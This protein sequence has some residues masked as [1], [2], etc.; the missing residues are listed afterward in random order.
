MPDPDRRQPPVEP[1]ALLAEAG[2]LRSMARRLVS[3]RE[4]ALELEQE[5]WRVA[6]EHPPR[7]GSSL[8]GWLRV[9]ATN[10]LRRHRRD[11]LARGYHEARASS[12]EEDP[13]TST[14]ERLEL[15][16][17]IVEAVRALSEPY[18]TAVTLRHLDGLD[19]AEV[20]RRTG[21]G[22]AA[23]RK[24]VSRGLQEL[25]G[26][27]DRSY[28]GRAGW[29]VFA[30]ALARDL[31]MPS[32]TAVTAATAGVGAGSLIAG[33]LSMSAG[34]KLGAAALATVLMGVSLWW[35][36]RDDGAAAGPSRGAVEPLGIALVAADAPVDEALEPAQVLAAGRVEVD[37]PEPVALAE[38]AAL[39]GI[40]DGRVVDGD[41]APISGAGVELLRIRGL[42][43]ET[44][45][46]EFARAEERLERA[47][48]DADGRFSFAVEP[49]RRYALR[50]G[51]EGMGDAHAARAR[52][53][54]DVTLR[55]MPAGSV[56]GFVSR[57]DDFPAI[58]AVVRLTSKNYGA[59][60]WRAATDGSGAFRFDGLEPGTYQVRA[61]S[62]EGATPNPATVI[63][64]S[65]R[66][67]RHDFELGEG[68]LVRGRVTDADTGAPLAGA[69][70]TES[71]VFH[72]V[73]RTDDNGEFTYAN[74]P[75]DGF[76]DLSIRAAGYG[77]CKVQIRGYFEE[78]PPK[79]YWEIALFPGAVVT[80]RVVDEA[81]TP[82]PD[83]YVGCAASDHDPDEPMLQQTDWRGG[84]TDA[85]GR[86]RI[87]D[88]RTDIPHAL[89]LQRDGL[90]AVSYEIGV[91]RGE[92]ELP[93]IV[94]RAGHV[95][96]GRVVDEAGEPR[97]GQRVGLLGHNADRAERF[98]HPLTKDLDTYVAERNTRTDGTGRFYFPDVADG[99]YRLEAKIPY[100]EEGVEAPLEVAGANVDLELALVAGLA[101][102]GLA[103]RPDG[104]IPPTTYLLAIREDGAGKRVQVLTDDGGRFR[105][106][107][108]EE[109]TYQIQVY[110]MPSEGA[111]NLAR[112]KL[113]GIAAGARDVRIQLEEAANLR[114]R[115][116]DSAGRGVSGAAVIMDTHDELGGGAQTDPDGYFELDPPKGVL[117]DL[118]AHPPVD[119]PDPNSPF[120]TDRDPER[121][122]RLDG[123][124]SDGDEVTLVLPDTD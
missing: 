5:T 108:L 116:V 24:R 106:G 21:V 85:D 40:I 72:N 59:G 39:E 111:P 112:Q 36:G 38:G 110:P 42:D 30:F 16:R 22:E 66:E 88:V 14:I 104:G 27:L 23:A 74:Y 43:Y 53:G 34:M 100:S 69:E 17:R 28:G 26:R 102:E 2:W 97:A 79:Q 82:L 94:L 98:G 89:F 32:S 9:V 61:F 58:G 87:D 35:A 113:E 31:P 109:G 19:Y 121:A 52:A 33:G 37:A 70:V 93:D 50:A 7:R 101:I 107:G 105:L 57:A 118:V 73:I 3:D 76:V 65:G 84:R 6:L 119:N 68:Y 1:E 99:A 8:R 41:D 123:V 64:E 48:T 11:D 10:L 81:G 86:Y 71:W 47:K 78:A 25:K 18:R 83:V 46:Q 13:E 49:R 62:S 44:L 115:V 55:L 90:G 122:A 4:V 15:Q 124:P 96:S 67:A 29:G 56:A 103:V 60:E 51:A 117:I 120:Q 63:V 91:P 12:S 75:K 45:D 77:K 95:V 20:A 92:V 54:D 114:G 80:G